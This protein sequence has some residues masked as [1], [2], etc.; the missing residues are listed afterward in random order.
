MKDKVRAQRYVS[1][2]KSDGGKPR[3]V[4]EVSEAMAM[5][6]IMPRIMFEIVSEMILIIIRVT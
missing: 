1:G 4:F 6:S 5:M 2:S 3:L